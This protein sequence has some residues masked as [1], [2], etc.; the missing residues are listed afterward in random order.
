[1]MDSQELQQTPY[2][3]PVVDSYSEHE[4]EASVEAVGGST[5]GGV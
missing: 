1:M 2:E 3:K 5:G 4:L